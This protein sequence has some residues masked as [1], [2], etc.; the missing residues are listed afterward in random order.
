MSHDFAIDKEQQAKL[1]RQHLKVQNE[2]A[3]LPADQQAYVREQQRLVDAEIAKQNDVFFNDS[4]FEVDDFLATHGISGSDRTD[5]IKQF[6]ATTKGKTFNFLTNRG[7][8]A[9]YRT[10]NDQ[11]MSADDY[12][13]TLEYSVLHT[14]KISLKKA[15]TSHS[16]WFIL[17]TTITTILQR[18]LGGFYGSE[19]IKKETTEA[20]S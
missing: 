20:N 8:K 11:L 10:L 7:Y 2:I 18:I 12:I 17:K 15:F 9:F 14:N 6:K 13:Y 19:E 1:E 16:I 3:K 5:F 4:M